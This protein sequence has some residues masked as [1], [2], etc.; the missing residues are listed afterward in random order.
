MD[1]CS[2]ST[3][4]LCKLFRFVCIFDHSAYFD[5]LMIVTMIPPHGIKRAL[6][7]CPGLIGHG[8]IERFSE[9]ETD[10]FRDTFFLS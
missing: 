7:P 4:H 3:L 9:L 2:K 1:H 6:E 10:L 8:S 5:D